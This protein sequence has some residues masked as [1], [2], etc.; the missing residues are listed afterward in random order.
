MTPG[1]PARRR[2]PPAAWSGALFLSD[3]RGFYLGPTPRTERHAHHAVQLCLGVDRP[4]R[5]RAGGAKT[6]S[7]AP[8]VLI[9]SDQPHEID[10]GGRLVALV[11][12]DPEGVEARAGLWGAHPVV[13]EVERA[14]RERLLRFWRQGCP[15]HAAG[16]VC[17]MVIDTVARRAGPAPPLDPRIGRALAVLRAAPDRR[18]ALAALAKTLAMSPSRLVHLFRQQTGI[19][20]RRYLLWLRLGDALRHSRR[21]R[22]LTE[23]AHES[24]FADS[25]HMCRTFRRMLGIAPST[26]REE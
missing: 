19:P 20:I 6:W 25:A 21:G 26:M 22:A 10:G 11:F 2:R 18:M 23:I 7:V 4:L 16:G 3:A 1:A 12:L 8:A 5:F 15:A 14:R 9:P 17:D 13:L 24:G